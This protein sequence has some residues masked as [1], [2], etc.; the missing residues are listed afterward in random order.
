MSDNPFDEP[1]DKD[2]TVIRPI[3]GGFARRPEPPADGASRPTIRRAIEPEFRAR[4]RAAPILDG[5]ELPLV[6]A[7]PLL[8]AASPLLNLMGRLRHLAGDPDPATLREQ[9]MQEL[10]RFDV[11]IQRLDLPR[12][13][14]RTAHYVLCASL[15]DVVMN[16]SWGRT[17]AWAQNSLVAMFHR[18]VV[19]GEGFFQ[20]LEELRRDPSNH[21]ELLALMYYCLSLGFQG[22]YR[23]LPR[24]ISELEALREAVYEILKRLH[25]SAER[26][27]S[28]RWP[29]EDAPYVPARATVPAWVIGAGVVTLLGV[30]FLVLSTLLG[31][32]ADVAMANAARSAPPMPTIQRPEAPRIV[33]PP[34]PPP[35]SPGPSAAA[36][37]RKFL[38]PEIRQGLVSVTETATTTRVEIRSSGMF[39]SGSGTLKPGFVPLLQRIGDALNTEPGRVLVI[40]HTDNQPIRTVRFPSNFQLSVARAEAARDVIGQKMREP[41]RLT[42]EGRADL[43]P[44]ASNDTAEGREAN[45]RIEIVLRRQE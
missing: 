8:A 2:R 26:G 27:L 23:V 16:T 19:A 14:V 42:A 44:V 9:A 11:A 17:G 3:P 21:Q 1:A 43:H 34:P 5:P 22:R 12:R 31:G 37:M 20:V 15:D 10:N 28:P 13:D 4:P 32:G 7:T 18:N 24:G 41:V 6:G 36:Q 30:L 35:P 29:G 38:E 39:P 45:R 25:P 40:G 33:A